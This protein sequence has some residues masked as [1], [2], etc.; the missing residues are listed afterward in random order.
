MPLSDDVCIGL[1]LANFAQD[2]GRDAQ[3]GRTYL[4]G[5]EVARLGRTGA[6]RA[7]CERARGLLASGKDLERAARG[8]F[9][10]QLALY[11]LGGLAICDAIERQEYRTE[12]HRPTVSKWTKALLMMRAIRETIDTTGRSRRVQPA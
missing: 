4:I 6:T 1:Q 12:E 5:E 10:L 7:L 9:R 11:R 3:L 8:F 2:V